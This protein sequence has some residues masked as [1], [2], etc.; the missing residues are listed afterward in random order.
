MNNR[1]KILVNHYEQVTDSALNRVAQKQNC[2]VFAK[3]R[4]ADVLPIE[5]S[6]LSDE[7][8]SY[9]LKSH[10]DFI[11]ADSEHEPLFAIEFDEPHHFTD[12]QTIRRDELKNSIC[13]FFEFPLLRIDASYLERVSGFATILDWV[14]EM[15]F[16]Q[17]WYHEAQ[18]RG[19]MPKDEEF[20]PT[21][22]F[23]W[24]YYEDERFIPAKDI[25]STF[26]ELEAQL[27]SQGKELTWRWYDPFAAYIGY[28]NRMAVIE[29]MCDFPDQVWG[30]TFKYT[31]VVR[32]VELPNGRYI[33]G[34]AQCHNHYFFLQGVDLA[35]EF[36]SVDLARKI[37]QYR[38]G[39]ETSC[40]LAEMEAMK[41]AVKNNFF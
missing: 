14:V 31:S 33:Y 5:K 2:R 10:F 15:W 16:A 36:A 1:K 25:N 17:R 40:S 41:I 9:A 30:H 32:Y 35:F 20:M 19:E 28:I 13:Q 34:H 24:G 26:E 23:E 11:F 37:A 3:V 8:Y 4:V 38:K 22:I 21:M 18:A 12:Q 39:E 7:E 6:G 27:S 29:R